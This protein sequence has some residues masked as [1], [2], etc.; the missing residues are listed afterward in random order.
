MRKLSNRHNTLFLFSFGNKNQISLKVL[1]DS[2]SHR[3]QSRNLYC[4]I[5]WPSTLLWFR[6]SYLL[7]FPFIS[8]LMT[9][10]EKKVV[11]CLTSPALHHRPSVTAFTSPSPPL[12]S[13]LLPSSCTPYFLAASTWTQDSV[14]STKYRLFCL[15]QF[16]TFAVTFKLI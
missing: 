12:P 5:Y 1:N 15:M 3:S 13:P 9:L 8:C 10:E 16:S 11:W 7:P 2:H 14:Q 4:Q 6:S